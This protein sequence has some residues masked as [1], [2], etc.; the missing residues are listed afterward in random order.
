MIETIIEG[1]LWEAR[2]WAASEG[3]GSIH[4][5]TTAEKLGFR[6]GT[7]PGDV[8]MNQ[9]PPVLL[10]LFG[11]EWF[12]TGHLSL[13]F[14]NA[15]TDRERVKVVVDIPKADAEQTDVRME[16]EDGMLVCSG[17]AGIGNH[18][19][20]ALQ[21]QDLRPCE[22]K[23]LRI[24]NKL[25]PGMSLGQ[26]EVFVSADKQIQRFDAGLIS[27]PLECYKDSSLFGG[28]LPAPCTVIEYLW[29]YPIQAIAPYIEESVGLFGA[30]EIAFH[31][32]PFFLN[33]NYQLQSE[34]ICVG[35]SP[36]TEYVWYKTNALD[37]SERTI[38]SMIMQ[39]RTM[40]ASSEVYQ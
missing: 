34:V 23:E 29:G 26:Y 10:K 4:D 33:Q 39:G 3:A 1:P 18:E 8:H 24:L 13:N 11:H 12:E 25:Y 40:K 17:T 27:D 20:S 32:G 14:K 21:T 30:I 37:A 36:Q 9:F 6:G 7:V 2:N 5:D 19:R 15:T 35:Q 38:A 22:P 28:I 16:R 31:D